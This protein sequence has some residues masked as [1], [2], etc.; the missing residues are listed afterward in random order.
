[1]VINM[2][3]DKFAKLCLTAC[4]ACGVAAAPV[5]SLEIQAAEVIATVQGTVASGTTSDLLRLSTKEGEMQ[6]KLD[7]QTDTSDCKILLPDSKV[8]VSVSHGSDGYLH[9]VKLSGDT[10][11]PATTL[12]SSTAATVTGTISSKSKGDVLCFKTAQG[13]MEIKL[14]PTTN[15]SG[16]SVLV[17]DKTY[18]IVCVRGSDAY[19]HAV[20]ITDGASGSSGSGS[21]S[22][23]GSNFTGVSPAPVSPVGVSTSTVTGTVT[24]DTKENLLCLSTNSGVMQ[25]A[26]DNNTDS[27]NGIIL[28]PDNKLTVSVYR[29]SD[30][31]MH[32]ATIIASKDGSQASVD[33]SSVSTVTGT[34]GSKS[35]E[36]ILYLS[37]SYGEMELKLDALN[38]VNNCKVLVSGKKVTVTC[39]RGNDAYMHAISITG[40]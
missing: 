26:I 17:A 25:I 13:E 18:S 35:N 21:S 36:N 8:S 7:S 6:I 27:R 19:M 28:T 33:T 11:T 39:A 1:M 30:A 29:G 3:K 20:S 37:T 32:A 38:S 22:S 23:S 15:L 4:L 24:S 10:Q 2:K 14:D 40:S 5:S 34:V 12:D 16:C 31:Y 9:A